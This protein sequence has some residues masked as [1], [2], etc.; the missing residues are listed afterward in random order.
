MYLIV[1]L[2]GKNPHITYEKREKRPIA[3]RWMRL[4]VWCV[5]PSRV[6]SNQ[7]K[8]RDECQNPGPFL[9]RPARGSRCREV[10]RQTKAG[11]APG[12]ARRGQRTRTNNCK[13]VKSKKKEGRQPNHPIDA[14]SH[15]GS[16]V[17][18]CPPC[19]LLIEGGQGGAPQHT[20]TTAN[21]FSSRLSLGA[22]CFFGCRAP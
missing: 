3:K 6:W 8:E 2:T 20:H 9:Q 5:R 16:F 13:L 10:G 22:V 1:D 19:P 11:L 4:C 21:P 7:E 15:L 18:V 14:E 17:S 12:R